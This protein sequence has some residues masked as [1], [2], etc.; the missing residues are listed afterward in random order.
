MAQNLKDEAG[1]SDRVQDQTH[2]RLKPRHIELIGIG[3]TIGTVLFVQ[4]GAGL[5]KGGPASLLL[6]FMLWSTVV[7]AVNNCSSEM[8]T[9]IPIS[10][11]FIR[12]ADHFADPALGFAAGINFFIFL[13]ALVPF[14]ITALTIVLKFWTDKIPV[15]A[16]V[17]IVLVSYAALNCLAVRY[18]GESEFWLALGKILLIIGLILFTFITM[19]GGNPLRDVYGFRYW[20]PSKVPG[21]P[22]AEY[23]GTGALGRFMGFLACLTQASMTIGGPEYVAMTAGEAMMPRTTL[24][25]AFR[26]VFYRLAAFFILGSLCVGIVVPYSDPELMSAIL[27]AKPGAATSPYVIAMERMHIPFLPHVVNAVVLTSIFS[28]GNSYVYGASRTLYGLALERKVPRFFLKCTSSGVPIACV[29]LTLAISCLCLY[30]L[31]FNFVEAKYRVA[32]LQVSNNSA[33][34]LQ[35]LLNLVAASALLNYAI[36]AFT[37]IRFYDVSAATPQSNPCKCRY[38]Q[39]LKLQG[40]SRSS[41][42]HRTSWQPWCA[43]YTIC[44]SLIMVLVNGYTVFLP[45]RWNT[46]S[47]VFSYAM[48]GV[49]P[50]LYVIWKV[51]FRTQ[52]RKLKEITFLDAERR[53]VDEYEQTECSTADKT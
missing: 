2:R 53:E 40:V 46:L 15:P 47:F 20:D 13:A 12:F 48:V 28:A 1:N 25:R 10:S 50:V 11:P 17:V 22:F 33:V 16:I 3:G 30:F 49:V 51:L 8:V 18:Y 52:W 21:A 27:N 43:Y 39:A 36:M 6:A 7:L 24:P 29:G 35:W 4:I 14:E 45:G 31:C 9:W 5:T 34:V 32:F 42:P 41:L 44:G 38:W 26:T 19:V 23:I 37:Y